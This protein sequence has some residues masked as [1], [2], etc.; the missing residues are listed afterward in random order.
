M[1]PRLTL[2]EQGCHAA[3]YDGIKSKEMIRPG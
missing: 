1:E 2:K 3:N